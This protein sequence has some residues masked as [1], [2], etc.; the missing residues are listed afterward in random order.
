VLW[1]VGK[2]VHHSRKLRFVISGKAGVDIYPF[3]ETT[4]LQGLNLSPPILPLTIM[5]TPLC[6]LHTLI[7]MKGSQIFCFRKLY[8]LI[9][10]MFS[11]REKSL[12]GWFTEI[13][14]FKA[15]HS[16]SHLTQ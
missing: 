15:I 9:D 10:H 14:I 4:N 5:L 2:L 11:G 6:L 8:E 1:D 3:R 12:R 16:S 7:R 13:I